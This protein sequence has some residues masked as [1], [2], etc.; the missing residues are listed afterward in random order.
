MGSISTMV[1]ISHVSTNT[2][3]NPFAVSSLSSILWI[4]D[5]GE[6]GEL[7]SNEI[8][9]NAKVSNLNFIAIAHELNCIA[10]SNEFG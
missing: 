4:S 8:L 7:C 6:C 5:G 1:P 9:I 3:V 10:E 2:A